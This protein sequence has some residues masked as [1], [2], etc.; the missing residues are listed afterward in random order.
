MLSN[1]NCHPSKKVNKASS[2]SVLSTFLLIILPKCPF[3]IMAYS[4]AIT[5]CGGPDM[6]LMSNNWVSFVPLAL[7]LFINVMLLLNWR[8]RRTFNALLVSLVGFSLI[9]MTHQLILSSGFYNLG[10]MLLFM[11]IWLNGSFIYLLNK[12]RSK[13]RPGILN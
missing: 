13:L 1:C 5:I 7:A 4:S 11:S 9:L 10:A 3:C 6:Y 12:I 8:G 2:V